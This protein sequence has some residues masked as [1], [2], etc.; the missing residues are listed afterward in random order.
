[1]AASMQSSASRIFGPIKYVERA[2]ISY[3]N[4]RCLIVR[5][6]QYSTEDR[7]RRWP[8]Q[9]QHAAPCPS[10]AARPRQPAGARHGGRGGA[11]VK[12]PLKLATPPRPGRRR[13]PTKPARIRYSGSGRD[14]TRGRAFGQKRT[15][16]S[17]TKCCKARQATGCC[18]RESKW[19]CG[20]VS[21][22]KQQWWPAFA[23]PF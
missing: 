15:V 6:S 10:P 5:V 1:M 18:S 21:R 14:H 8:C 11:R 13:L 4:K 19:L 2:C 23:N 12:A 22:G 3:V 17:T 16:K 9:Q 20:K 7:S